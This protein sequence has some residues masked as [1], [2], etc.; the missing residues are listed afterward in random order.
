MLR[1]DAPPR[2]KT[3]TRKN[4]IN[5]LIT[6]LVIGIVVGTPIGWFI[7]RVYFQQRLAQ[8]LVC[9]EQNI[10]QPAAVLETVCGSKF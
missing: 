4:L 7:H 6:G 2:E 9:R 3:I 5:S 1:Q 10:N 8:Y